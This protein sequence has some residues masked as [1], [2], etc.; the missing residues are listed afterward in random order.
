MKRTLLLSSF[1]AAASLT[2]IAQDANKA[3]AITVMKKYFG[4]T[5]D[6]AMGATWEYYA[7]LVRP[8]LPYARIDQFTDLVAELAKRNDQVKLVDLTKVLD[9]SFV[10]SAADR[11]LS[12]P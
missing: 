11:G 4:S 10:Q 7:K 12:R 5:D 1:I 6:A 8:Q 9:T 3:Y 2:S